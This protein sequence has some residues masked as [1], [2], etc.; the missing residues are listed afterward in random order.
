MALAPKA[1]A[2]RVAWVAAPQSLRTRMA[3]DVPPRLQALGDVRIAERRSLALFCSARCPGGP[4]LRALDLA[5]ELR[6]A[7]LTVVGGFHSPVEQDCLTLLLRGTA[8]IVVCPARD[9]TGMRVPVSWRPALAS[10]RLLVLSPFAGVRRVTARMARARNELVAAL[11]DE[12]LVLHAAAGSGTERLALA[13]LTAG[14]TVLT[15][16]GPANATLIARGAAAVESWTAYEAGRAV[17][18]S[19]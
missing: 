10:G 16:A 11:A 5:R 13:L 1:A 8:R 14:R 2:P 17:E 12:V 3:S 4:I 19:G 15:P 7:D 18:G 9:I 6:D